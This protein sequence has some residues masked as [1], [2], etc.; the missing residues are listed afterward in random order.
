MQSTQPTRHAIQLPPG[1]KAISIHPADELIP[2]RLCVL[3][4]TEPDPVAGRFFLLRDLVGARVYLGC[5]CDAG[6]RVQEWI[7][8]W[9]QAVEGIETTLAAHRE[10]F[11]NSILDQRWI[12]QTLACQAWAPENFIETGWEFRH[13]PPTFIDLSTWKVLCPSDSTQSPLWRLC[14]DD[15]LLQKAELPAYSSS[16]V[17]YLYQKSAEPAS[18]FVPVVS[19]APES[20]ATVPFAQA[21]SLNDQVVTFNEQ[22]GLM[23]VTRFHPFGYEEYV[24]L[25]SGKSWP[26]LVHGK[27]RLALGEPYETLLEVDALQ[28]SDGY[29]FHGGQGR[30][31]RFVETLHLKLHLLIEAF[32]CVRSSIKASQLPLLNLTPESFRV[33]L[34]S[35]SPGLPYLWTSQCGLVKPSQAH[36]LLVQTTLQRLFLRAGQPEV[37]TYLPEGQ[38]SGCRG[39]GAVRLRKTLPHESNGVIVEGTLGLQE[40]VRCSPRDILWIRLP[41]AS[42]I[43]DLFGHIE[44]EGLASAEVRFRTLPQKLPEA[45]LT[46]L[47]S[48]TML[49]FP[50]CQYEVIPLLSSPSDLYSLTVL[51]VRTLLVNDKAALPAALDD[52]LS[53]ARQAALEFTAEVPLAARIQS[54][55]D[56]KPQWLECLGPHRLTVEEVKP[57]EGVTMVPGELW[58]EVLAALVRCLPG[59]GPD[60]Y[61]A[62]LADAQPLALETVFDRPTGD[63]KRLRVKTRSLLLVDWNFNRE[64]HATI[65]ELLER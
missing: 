48:N 28:K 45:A 40:A 16:L 41:L 49:A 19:N 18:K 61:C 13:P 47:L 37:S 15:I 38:L 44:S 42:G 6:G 14:E 51:A 5:V 3:L 9:T 24:D 23:M 17:R 39:L 30:A 63:L 2:L 8:I 36:A 12:A 21:L 54:I 1:F 34:N 64:V 59:A 33:K 65:D 32:R 7:E 22:G 10:A 35:L 31:G 57:Q 55:F 29:L 46:A 62:D 58:F 4:R 60:S 20:A 11:S 43:V 26:G 27:T 52:L 25:L 53:L 56:R 50:R